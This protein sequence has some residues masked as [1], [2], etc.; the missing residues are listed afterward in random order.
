MCVFWPN[1]DSD[2]DVVSCVVHVVF[3]VVIVG[4]CCGCDGNDHGEVL[5]ILILLAGCPSIV[6]ALVVCVI[7]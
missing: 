2:D 7:W 5:V 3:M 4:I 1:G 6:V